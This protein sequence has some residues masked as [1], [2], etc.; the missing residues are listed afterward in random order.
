MSVLQI[1]K[2]DEAL[3]AH[4]EATYPSGCYGVFLGKSEPGVGTACR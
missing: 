1:S 4:G 2:A 3:Q